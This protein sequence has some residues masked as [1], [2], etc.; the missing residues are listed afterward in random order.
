[1]KQNENTFGNLKQLLKLKRHEVPPPGYFNNFSDSVISRIRAGE[2]G[3]AQS[4]TERLHFTAPW[5]ANFLNIFE[6]KPG[7]IGGFAVSLCLLLVLGVVFSERSDSA[8]KN[9]LG[10]VESAPTG[11]SLASV[12]A[13]QFATAADSTGIMASTNPVTSLQPASTLFGQP[14]P[15]L[16]QSASFAPAGN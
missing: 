7:L 3:G 1:M 15:T 9:I 4:V 10:T 2:A 13:P 8:P 5:L 11:G 16:F 6:T 12:S 14:N